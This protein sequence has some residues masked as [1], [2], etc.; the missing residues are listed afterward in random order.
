[1]GNGINGMG[2]VFCQHIKPIKNPQKPFHIRN[3]RNLLGIPIY[4]N[5]NDAAIYLATLSSNFTRV[6]QK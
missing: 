6:E 3:Y 1:M 4:E 2:V 5:M